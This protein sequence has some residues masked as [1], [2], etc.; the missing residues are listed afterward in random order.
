[1]STTARPEPTLHTSILTNFSSAR[2]RFQLPSLAPPHL[3][4]FERIYVEPGG[5]EREEGEG[6]TT[7]FPGSAGLSRDLAEIR[8]VRS[9]KICGT[10]P[11]DRAVVSR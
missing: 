10:N 9:G 6:P 2:R 3:P 7:V 8:N 1:M 11:H 5:W 4:A